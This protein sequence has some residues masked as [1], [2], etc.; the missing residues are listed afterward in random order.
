MVT[1]RTRSNLIAKENEKQLRANNR[2]THKREHRTIPHGLS[3]HGTKT[4]AS[5]PSTLAA[6]HWR[7][8]LVSWKLGEFSL[9]VAN[10]AVEEKLVEVVDDN[11]LHVGEVPNLM[12]D[13]VRIEQ[14]QKFRVQ[15]AR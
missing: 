2:P 8:A 14:T 1:T 6:A 11:V 7:E 3:K 4:T 13:V 5:S 15:L 10:Q 12:V 9:Q